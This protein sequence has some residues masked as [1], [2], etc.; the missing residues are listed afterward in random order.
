MYRS[1][2]FNAGYVKMTKIRVLVLLAYYLPGYKSGGPVRSI[3]NMVE[4]LGDDL[5]FWIVTRDRDKEDTGPHSGITVGSW[6]RIGKAMVHYS[7]EQNFT[8]RR[9][10]RLIFDIKP[11]IIYINSFFSPVT[12]FFLLLRRIGAWIGTWKLPPV[13]L[14][15]R[16]EFSP[17]AL[18]IKWL[19]KVIYLKFGG[20]A[21]LWHDVTFHASSKVEAEQIR[22]R[23]RRSINVRVASNIPGR[24][25]HV[26]LVRQGKRADSLRLVFISRIVEKKNLLFVLHLL[27]HVEYETVLDVYGPLESPEYWQKCKRVIGELPANIQLNYR[28]SVENSLVASI[29]SGY[30]ALIFPTLGENFG[31]V[32]FESLSAGCPVLLSDRTPWLDLV[33][34]GLGWDIPLEEP[35]RW[36]SAIRECAAMDDARHGEM[37]EKCIA[38]A[39]NWAEDNGINLQNLRL[40]QGL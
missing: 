16:G 29:L 15:P 26:G 6:N 3:A 28:G 4:Q 17:G 23:L 19:K 39:D 33:D 38:F 27:Q 11:N 13:I 24:T 40:F 21:G 8:A 12:I 10:C 1:A 2:H 34:M 9:V 35:G 18:N 25:S 22:V 14:A 36:L 30:D 7:P 32:I 37:A 5:D 20:F 31:H